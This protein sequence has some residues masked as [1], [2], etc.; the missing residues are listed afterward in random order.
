MK[1]LAYRRWGVLIIGMSLLALAVACATVPEGGS[2][3]QDV[4]S[5]AGKWEGWGTLARGDRVSIKLNI[6]PDGKWQMRISPPYYSYG[7]VHYGTSVY[8]DGKFILDTPT[9][10]LNGN[11]TL[12]YWGDRAWLIFN[13]DNASLRADLKRTF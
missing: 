5:I 9:P 12:H 6:L 3:T 13:T 1:N 11:C 2:K 7:N 8:N 4:Q 10:G